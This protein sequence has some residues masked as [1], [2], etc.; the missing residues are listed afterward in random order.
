[1]NSGIKAIARPLHLP[2]QELMEN[3]KLAPSPTINNEL[4]NQS[5]KNN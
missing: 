3:D 4:A 5:T 1:M 2:Q